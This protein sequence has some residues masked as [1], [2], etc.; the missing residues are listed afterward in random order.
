MG[1][2]N[3]IKKLYIKPIHFLFTNYSPDRSPFQRMNSD[4]HDPLRHK[5]E[6]AMR[7]EFD[8]ALKP[9][10]YINIVQASMKSIIVNYLPFNLKRI[11]LI[12]FSK[13][14]SRPWPICTVTL[15]DAFPWHQ[16]SSQST[17]TFLR[18]ALKSIT[19]ILVDLAT[20]IL[21]SF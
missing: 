1:K 14:S 2:V 13:V 6:K 12:S 5:Q 21:S 19:F 7:N 20:G 8:R 4:G 16:P 15:S 3:A 10:A 9:K 17:R 18:S 11:I